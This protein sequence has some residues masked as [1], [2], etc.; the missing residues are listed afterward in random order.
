[1]GIAS[2]KAKRA[3]EIAKQGLVPTQAIRATH[4]F[5]SAET[6]RKYRAGDIIPVHEL[7]K[8]YQESL[9]T[10]GSSSASFLFKSIHIG[11]SSPEGSGT[12][13]YLEPGYAITKIE[14]M[15]TTMWQTNRTASAH[16]T[17]STSGNRFLGEDPIDLFTTGELFDYPVGL[18]S[19]EDLEVDSLFYLS[20]GDEFGGMPIYASIGIQSIG[21]IRPFHF[22]YGE[23]YLG[24]WVQPIT[25]FEYNFDGSFFDQDSREITI[26]NIGVGDKVIAANWYIGS[27]N[28]NAP[29]IGM[30]A[31]LG[32]SGNTD[33]IL[34]PSDCVFEQGNT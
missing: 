31:E 7:S 1:M 11:I 33:A 3:A 14:Y 12:I 22:T 21:M 20:S 10:E 34:A 19:H 30:S 28:N 15:I 17:V 8:D 13:F 18:Y 5:T 27:E 32:I 2:R 26:G 29:S 4:S 24:I 9:V 23:G 6:G 25:E 16:I